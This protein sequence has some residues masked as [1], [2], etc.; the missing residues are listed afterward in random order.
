VTQE[1]IKIHA[2]EQI[3]GGHNKNWKYTEIH[4]TEI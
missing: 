1:F 2:L 4:V 3:Y